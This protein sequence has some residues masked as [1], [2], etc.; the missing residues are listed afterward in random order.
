MRESDVREWP[1]DV[2]ET[3]VDKSVVRMTSKYFV[4][5]LGSVGENGQTRE[6]R[7]AKS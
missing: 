3:L 4:G 2:T 5:T 6:V 1:R 7:G